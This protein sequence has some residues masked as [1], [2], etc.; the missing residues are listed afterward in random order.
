MNAKLNV[1][2]VMKVY[3]SN[4][5]VASPYLN[6]NAKKILR[7]IVLNILIENVFNVCLII[8]LIIKIFV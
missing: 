1:N 2:N 3:V 7:I 5:K 4:V 6:I 8:S